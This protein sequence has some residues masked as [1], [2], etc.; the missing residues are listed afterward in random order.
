[1][2]DYKRDRNRCNSFSLSNQQIKG[3]TKAMPKFRLKLVHCSNTAIYHWWTEPNKQGLYQDV[4]SC[5][6]CFEEDKEWVEEIHAT[7]EKLSE[8]S[9]IKCT[10]TWHEET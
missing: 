1:M 8:D 7:V 3:I 4:Y 6:D 5:E 2:V 9:T 10:G